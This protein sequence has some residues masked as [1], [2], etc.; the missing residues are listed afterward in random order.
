MIKVGYN[1]IHFATGRAI[2]LAKVIGYWKNLSKNDKQQ[3]VQNARSCFEDFYTPQKNRKQI[4]AIYKSM[5]N[6]LRQ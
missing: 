4:L 1:G 5:K 6:K 2:D 3:F